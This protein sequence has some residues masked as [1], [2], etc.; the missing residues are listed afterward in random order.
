MDE[1]R[2]DWCTSIV[3]SVARPRSGLSSSVA[4]EWAGTPGWPRCPDSINCN[5]TI[6]SFTL[7]LVEVAL[8]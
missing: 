6:L 8:K 4:E 1:L 2:W 7:L 5:T 3:R